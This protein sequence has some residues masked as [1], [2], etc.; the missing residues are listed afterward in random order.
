MK[1]LGNNLAVFFLV[2]AAG[3]LTL[4]VTSVAQ[5]RSDIPGPMVS[6]ETQS[7]Q[8]GENIIPQ[9]TGSIRPSGP[10]E[11]GSFSVNGYLGNLGDAARYVL[12]P[13]NTLF[14]QNFDGSLEMW[15]RPTD[16]SA[17][18]EM[19]AKGATANVAFIWG[20]A[21]S[22][23]GKQYFRIGTT[24]YL[25]TDGV[26]VPLDLWSHVAVTWSGGPSTFTVTF[27]VNGSQSGT[28]VTLAATWNLDAD[29][30]RIG[31]GQNWPTEYFRGD[32]DE[33]RLWNPE[34]TL[35]QIRDNRFVGVGDGG[36]ANAGGALTSSSSYSGLIS[37]W[38]FNTAGTAF[39]DFG[40]LH[41]SYQGGAN[42]F[43]AI[44][45]Q[46]IPYNLALNCAGG[47]SADYVVVPDNN[48]FNQN[49][50]GT[51]DA[52]IH[53]T[54]SGTTRWMI[55]KGNVGT[56]FSFGV[57]LA[58]TDQLAMRI[59]A[60][61]VVNSDGST[62]P[63]NKWTHVAVKWAGSS[64][65]YTATFYVNGQQSGSPAVVAGTWNI[66]SDS[67]TI[68][69]A[70]AFSGSV[71]VMGYMDEVRLWNSAL[72]QA[73]IVR[74]M[75]VSGRGLL[76]NPDLLAL[77]N[78]DGNLN[79]FSAT[80][81][82]NGSF[83]NG[84]IN[85]CRFS[86]YKNESNAGAFS[87]S[88]VA[89]P[90]VINRGGAPN[91]FPGGYTV[92]APF[93]DIPDNNP[94]GISD[95]MTISNSMAVTSVEVFLSVAHTF[96]G[97]LIVTLEAPNGQVRTLTNRNGSTGDGILTFFNDG[98]SL[99]ATST[100]YFAPWAFLKPIELMGNFGGANTAGQ[101]TLKVSDNAGIDLGV[102]Q[103][104]GLRF[105]NV[106]GVEQISASVPE[107]FE[108]SQ[109]YPNPFNPTTRIEFRLPEQA[110]VL[111]KIYNV[112]GQEV[113]TLVDGHLDAGH[114]VETWDSRSD[115]GLVLSSGVYF[116][117][118]T[119]EGVSGRKYGDL[120]KMMLLK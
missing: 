112:V 73:E 96:V 105:N 13:Y 77:W 66:T 47:S 86:A 95:A 58:S 57:A 44:A 82:I 2:L 79:N 85:N 81:G 104:W 22:T 118:L 38:T 69:I 113:A 56:N 40:G 102:L 68:G 65:N 31:A 71:P 15:V 24:V 111:L 60:S 39:D 11:Y 64:G 45:G 115:N 91:P 4:A 89:H 33:V 42:A 16:F 93:I 99:D 116:Y 6:S 34:R 54:S 100:T 7:G 49:A 41:G 10:D 25:N 43:Q 80:A 26:A 76:P 120:K 48:V 90:T 59:G 106:T 94:T 70:R 18:M 21:A 103:G 12:V 9:Y 8:S 92:R 35:A 61:A 27:Y 83:N 88:F 55:A 19:I 67:L 84:G 23:P 17:T 5:E 1:T 46:P 52:W 114:F 3:F 32:I 20:F 117:R 110:T 78:F 98:F 109:N 53:P 29:S 14:G 28:P 51:F 97:D 107:S 37:S 119:A 75:F 74:Y 63:I 50:D 62:I 87:R 101:W 30:V 36:A 108:L 72:T